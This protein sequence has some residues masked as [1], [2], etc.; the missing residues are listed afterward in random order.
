MCEKLWDVKRE[1][2]SISIN[3]KEIRAMCKYLI[4]LGNYDYI[5]ELIIQKEAKIT[6]DGRVFS[7]MEDLTSDQSFIS[8]KYHDENDSKESLT[9]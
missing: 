3:K 7:G 6:L 4:S 2:D 8:L 9:L 1:L 5:D